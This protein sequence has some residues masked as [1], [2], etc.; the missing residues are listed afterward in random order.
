M[1]NNIR[2]FVVCIFILAL[3]G[4]SSHKPDCYNESNKELRLRWGSLITKSGKITGYQ[5]NYDSK[6]LKIGKKEDNDNFTDSVLTIID[7]DRYCKLLAM[8]R[9]TILKIQALSEPGD[10]LHFI[11]YSDPPRNVRMRAVWNPINKT[12]GSKGFREI[13]DSLQTLL[14]VV[15]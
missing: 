3:A 2:I 5:L 13:Y 6:L 1:Y 7:G 14:P 4:C 9:D 12:Y 11:E 15:R 10:S 8:T